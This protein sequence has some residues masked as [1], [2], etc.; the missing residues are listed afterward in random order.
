MCGSGHKVYQSS[1]SLQST[2]VTGVCHQAQQPGHE[3]SHNIL[4]L[5][6]RKLPES[7]IIV[8]QSSQ[9][10]NTMFA[11][12]CLFISEELRKCFEARH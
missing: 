11:R 8:K 4:F 1:D 2:K 5:D 3:H 9:R 10:Y 6:Y 7:F 12:L